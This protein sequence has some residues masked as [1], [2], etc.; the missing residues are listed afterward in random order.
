VDG[1]N[2]TEISPNDRSREKR[3]QLIRHLED[4]LVLA[5]EIEDGRLDS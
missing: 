2:D 3:G 5:D 1:S 4:A